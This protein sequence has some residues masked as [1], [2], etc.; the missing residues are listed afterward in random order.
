MSSMLPLFYMRIILKR[1]QD[2]DISTTNGNELDIERMCSFVCVVA[3]V[4]SPI[5]DFLFLLFFF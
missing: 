4:I 3:G 5:A 2:Y 1:F